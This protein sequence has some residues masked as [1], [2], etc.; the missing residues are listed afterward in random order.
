M[1][2][3]LKL[4]NSKGAFPSAEKQIEILGFKYDAK[5]MGG[6]PTISATVMYSTC[7]DNVWSDDVY[8]EFNGEKYYL[9]HTPTSS[10]SNEDERYKH[11]VTLVSERYLLDSIYFIDVAPSDG[12]ND[13]PV[14]NSATFSFYGTIKEFAKRL[15]AAFEYSKLK[16]RVE[17]DKIVDTEE[18]FLSFDKQVLSAVLQESYNVF[19]VPYYFVGKKIYFDF[20]QSALPN[21]LK[22]GIDNELLSIT[23]SNENF[24]I[25]N[26]CTGTGSAE[27]IP[28]YYPNEHPLGKIKT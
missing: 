25:V 16:Y 18:K 7:L 2:K 8:V 24:K 26:R 3:A 23:K 20:F 17:I 6:A 14:T 12:A 1:E 19:Q 21:T 5:R 13:L 27:N 28:Y 22:Y 10:K 9:N 4:Y 11:E 15:N